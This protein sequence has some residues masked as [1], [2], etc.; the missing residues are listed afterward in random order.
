MVASAWPH[1]RE[2]SHSGY[3]CFQVQASKEGGMRIQKKGLKDYLCCCCIPRVIEHPVAIVEGQ[4]LLSTGQ[5]A[6]MR[7]GN[8]R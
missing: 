1:G 3:I 6:A 2:R 4:E 8:Y 5:K 7:Q